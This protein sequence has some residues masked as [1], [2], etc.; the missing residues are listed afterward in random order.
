MRKQIL[1]FLLKNTKK[2]CRKIF[3][4]TLPLEFNVLTPQTR[5]NLKYGLASRK[6]YKMKPGY[7][8]QYTQCHIKFL[9]PST[10]TPCENICIIIICTNIKFNIPSPLVL[11]QGTPVPDTRNTGSELFCN[12]GTRPCL[13]YTSPS[14]RD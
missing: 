5:P 9:S 2:D 10:P 1:D 7:I 11:D 3:I 8:V 6:M 4:C 13:L 12:T 14:P